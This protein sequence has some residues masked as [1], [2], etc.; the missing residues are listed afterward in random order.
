MKTK[1]TYD[2][3]YLDTIF[4]YQYAQ[5]HIIYQALNNFIYNVV[6]VG[7]FVVVPQS[8]LLQPAVIAIYFN[9]KCGPLQSNYNS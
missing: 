9:H 3:F 5:L 1:S 2:I 6:K 8:I 7:Y 4:T